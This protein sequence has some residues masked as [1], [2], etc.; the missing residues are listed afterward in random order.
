MRVC[1][2]ARVR[3]RARPR[4]CVCARARVPV[5]PRVCVR[6]RVRGC[7]RM[8]VC[9]CGFER[10]ALSAKKRMIDAWNGGTCE[11]HCSTVPYL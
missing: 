9:V 11:Y 7:V 3:A 2:C 5:R 4:V 8:S 1:A 6:A 10:R